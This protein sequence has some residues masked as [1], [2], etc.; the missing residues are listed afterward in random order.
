MKKIK[1]FLFIF[2]SIVLLPFIFSCKKT[3]LYTVSF[4][5]LG[6]SQI[7]EI[8]VEGG[9]TIVAPSNPVYGLN[10]F[11]GWFTDEDC[12]TQFDF[13]TSINSDITLF[14]KWNRVINIYTV[15]DF[16]GAIEDK[17]AKVGEYLISNDLDNK[18]NTIILSAGD[19]FQG[20]GLSNYSRGLD[21]INIMNMIGFDAMSVGNHEFDWEL[22]TILNYFD[23]DLT[24]G[25]AKFPILGCNVVDKTTG[26]IPANMNAYTI[27]EKED[28]KIGIIGYIGST[29]EDSIASDMVN[30]YEFLDPVPIISNISTDLHQNH[31]VDI[32]IAL[33][34]DA[35]DNVNRSLVN[36]NGDSRVDA[37]INGHTHVRSSGTI[38]RSSD[39]TKVPYV[40]AG[41]SGEA[42]GV[43]SLVLD[44]NNYSV[45][46]ATSL[47]KLITSSAKE[48][49]DI[50]NYVD[51]ILEDTSDYFDRVIGVSG[52]DLNVYDG[53][54]WAANSILDYCKEKYSVCDVAF[55]NKGGIR[56][57]A[58]P[59][60]LDEEITIKRIFSMMPFDNTINFSTIKG[61]ILRNLIINGTELTYST[62]SVNVDGSNVYINGVL[63]NDDATYRVAVVDYIFD[64]DTYPFKKGDDVYLTGILL[65]DILIQNI[66]GATS[67][68]NKCFIGKE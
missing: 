66:E 47:T 15:N 37:I 6:G 50:K 18:E 67:S 32:V 58:F 3:D 61:N 4:N 42:V 51:K 21:M 12:S 40:Q 20:S 29:L 38:R 39:N 33:G 63:L 1:N 48:N 14:A 7:S 8:T 68:G 17:A 64:K 5:S 41:S 55:I 23:S 59:I 19:M 16:H 35:S 43:I 57:S 34:H 10:S 54:N 27:I 44:S 60:K 45:E 65:R 36:L 31:N 26:L 28:I 53:S 49:S 56:E 46:N 25:E 9:N 62:N 11:M 52:T 22:N 13:T 24:N 2:L 30:N